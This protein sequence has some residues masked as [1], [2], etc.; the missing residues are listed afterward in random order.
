MRFRA[1]TP[2]DVAWFSQE[3]SYLP[4]SQFTGVV[5]YEDGPPLGM[6]GLDCWTHTAVQAHVRVRD[7]KV[8]VP[9][10]REVLHYLR[11]HGRK[12]IV[13]VT[14]ADNELSIRLQR[15]LGFEEKYRCKDG[16][17]EGVDM[18]ISEYRIHE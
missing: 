11:T 9:L 16:W 17:N 12:L 2:E 4:G 8:L 5:A 1:A 15:A 14:P 7:V 13:G 10:W 3:V 18:V 6:V